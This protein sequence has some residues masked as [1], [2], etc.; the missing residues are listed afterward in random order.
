HDADEDAAVGARH[1]LY[2]ETRIL[3]GFPRDLEQQTMLWIHA[4]HLARRDPE[5]PPIASPHV[6]QE[7]AP[8]RHGLP[9][10]QGIGVIDILPPAA[11]HRVNQVWAASELRPDLLGP[12]GVPGANPHADNGKRL[13]VGRRRA[14]A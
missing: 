7:R 6:V 11:R 3:E 14:N 8:A 4:A 5:E 13:G 2:R 1:T 12:D 9:G 10:R